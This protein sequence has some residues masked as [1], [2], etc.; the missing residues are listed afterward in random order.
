MS[1]NVTFGSARLAN[2]PEFTGVEPSN[3]PLDNKGYKPM[4]NEAA[5]V[6]GLL[7]KLTTS[8]KLSQSFDDVLVGPQKDGQFP[9]THSGV[10]VSSLP[11]SAR[12][13]V[14]RLIA[15]YVGD[16]PAAISKPLIARYKKQYSRT[17]V[18]YAG[19]TTDAP[20]TYLRIDG[21]RPGSSSPCR[22]PTRAPGITTP[23]TATNGT[24]TA[25]STQRSSG[26]GRPT[27]VPL[28]APCASAWG[29]SRP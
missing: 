15:A 2:T 25:R 3:F 1:F 24:T 21:P 6:F 9:S 26:C 14:T 5:A 11:A 16:V 20:G 19:G 12:K 4:K 18:S 13:D 28:G 23:S 29:A 10:K 27:G 8:A 22:R 17:Y 7:P